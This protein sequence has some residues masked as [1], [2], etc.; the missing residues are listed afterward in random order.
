MS[1][2]GD[3]LR[4]LTAHHWSGPRSDGWYLNFIGVKP[5]YQGQGYG[6]ELVTWGIQQADDD[7]VA[8][9]VIS[10]VGKDDFYRK[11]GLDVE[12]GNVTD[13]E[14]NPLKG[15]TGGGAILFRNPRSP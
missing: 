13:G 3:R 5:S 9:S 4:P 8:A 2:I 15:R 12:V 10:G 14:G 6:G 7:N 11:Y 1:D